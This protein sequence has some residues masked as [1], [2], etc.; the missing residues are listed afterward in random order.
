[1]S[2]DPRIAAPRPGRRLAAFALVVA[3]ASGTAAAQAPS[4]LLDSASQ[5]KD[6]VFPTT[7]SSLGLFA[8]P[9]MAL[10]KPEGNGP[11]PALVLHHQCGGLS[12]GKLPNQSM[13]DWA[14]RAVERGYVVL[15]LDTL[16]PRD[17]RTVCYGPN[18][19]VNFP[20]GVRDALQAAQHLRTLPFVDGR[21][22]AHAGYS[23]GAMVGAL[24]SGREWSTAL[25]PGERFDAVVSFYPGCFTIGSGGGNPFEI[26]SAGIDR[27]LLVL[28]GGKDTE[29]P[30]AQ[31]E[32]RLAPLKASGAPV[33]WH[34]Y[35]DAT[36]CWD[37]R[38]LDGFS[39]TD[40]RG[41][42]VVYRYDR[43]LT[44]DSARRMF[45]FLDRTLKPK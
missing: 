14:K 43:E 35:P 36:H 2:I 10:Y 39:K 32:S 8:Y 4:R 44:E 28:M 7:P 23:W 15:M 37:C 21:R 30:A 27:P 6:L 22:I 18:G 29:T 31:C 34:T 1:M 16:G 9:R 5:A 12:G 20:R 11:F 3:L 26:V 17:V 38:N 13:L 24:A 19:G 25:A 45:D 40:A 41:N 42:H 33:E